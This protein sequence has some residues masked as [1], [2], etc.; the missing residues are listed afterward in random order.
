MKQLIL[1]EFYAD[2]KTGEVGRALESWLGGSIMLDFPNREESC[3]SCIGAEHKLRKATRQEIVDLL[4][5]AN[6]TF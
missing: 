2:K 4:R 5:V 3:V 1:G 6:V